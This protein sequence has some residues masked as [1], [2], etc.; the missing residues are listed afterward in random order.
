M[1][2]FI[3][4]N[5]LAAVAL[6]I[7][8]C[9]GLG[10][11]NYYLFSLYEDSD[12]SNRMQRICNNNWK[13]YLGIDQNEWFSFDA[14]AVAEAAQKKND[15]LMV[16]YVRELDKYLQV[17]SDVYSDQWD[18]PTKEKLAKRKAKLEAVRT[19]A[20]TKLRSKLRSQHALLYMRANMM[21]NRHAENV[22]FWETTASQYIESVY[23]D[24]MKNIYAG[25]LYKTG[26]TTKAGDI[27]AEQGDYN[28]LMTVFYL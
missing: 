8:A 9:A 12:F 28:S 16:S 2:K 27:F 11:Y 14:D 3:I 26:Q 15:P 18:Y 19:Y 23:K 20:A 10:S 1:K 5:L 24:M 21:L 4:T 25:A 13:A 6:P 22:T 7:L 17:A